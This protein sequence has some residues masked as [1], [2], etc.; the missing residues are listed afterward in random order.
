M[1]C[2]GC[3]RWTAEGIARALHLPLSPGCPSPMEYVQPLKHV[4][5]GGW[6][7]SGVILPNQL[8][9]EQCDFDVIAASDTLSFLSEYLA[10]QRPVLV[11]NAA[12]NHE[13]KSLFQKWQRNKF[14]QEYGALTF[15]EVDVPFAESFRYRTNKTSLKGF[16]AKMKQLYQSHQ[17]WKAELE[18]LT[19]PTYIFETIPLDSPLLRD[20]KLPDVLNPNVTHISVTKMQFYLG[21]ALSGAPQHFHRSAWNV[22]IFGQ[23]R[24]FLFPPTDAI[25]SRQHVWEWWKG[26]SHTRGLECVQHPGD[27]VFVPDMWGHAV[28]NLRE[29]IGFASEFVYGASEFSI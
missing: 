26:R 21:P 14:E 8:T 13:M 19:H 10:L 6:L 20:F 12:N 23:K 25:Y 4:S 15:N 1:F 2:M 3:F 9:R 22:L 18:T 11:R 28:I 16:M 24:W 27:L 5:H 17:I 7:G 29:S